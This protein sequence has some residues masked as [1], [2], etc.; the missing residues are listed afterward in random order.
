[1]INRVVLFSKNLAKAEV[2][3]DLLLA[4][5]GA[6]KVVENQNTILW[7]AGREGVDFA[8]C[9][10]EDTDNNAGSNAVFCLQA[11]TSHEVSLIYRAA[12]RLGASCAG[13]PSCIA[14]GVQAAY[15]FDVDNNKVGIFH[16]NK[17]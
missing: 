1:M 5:F 15:F 6:K 8:I 12:L 14:H 17:G 11:S 13:K 2:F 16:S 10:Q 4:L 7:K 9:R 3:Y